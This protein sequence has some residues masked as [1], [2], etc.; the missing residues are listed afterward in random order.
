MPVAIKVVNMVPKSLSNSDSHDREPNITVN[1]ANTLQ[2]VGTAFTPDPAGTDNAPVYISN[3]GGNTWMLNAIVPGSVPGSPIGTA[4]ITPRFSS[5]A[6]YVGDI[7]VSDFKMDVAR[8]LNATSPVPMTIVD[9][10]LPLADQ[11]YVEATT[12]VLGP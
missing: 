12:V 1:P 8:T 5:K 11:P 2:I 4:D 6:L 9:Q 3:D 10:K 7:R